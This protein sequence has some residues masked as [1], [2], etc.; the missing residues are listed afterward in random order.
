[1]LQLRFYVETDWL[2]KHATKI[3]EVVFENLLENWAGKKL[4]GENRI[5]YR[6][7][8]ESIQD[9]LEG[10]VSEHRKREEKGGSGGPKSKFSVVI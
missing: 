1:M 5:L 8:F 2:R 7:I 9:I 10:K 4:A 6:D 3:H